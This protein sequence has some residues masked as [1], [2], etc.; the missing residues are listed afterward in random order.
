MNEF[1]ITIFLIHKKIMY[2]IV[3]HE[4][5]CVYYP[6]LSLSPSTHTHTHTHTDDKLRI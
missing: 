3:Y 4:I 1:A 6:F 5:T 2:Q